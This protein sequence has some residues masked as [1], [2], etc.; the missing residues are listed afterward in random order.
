[1]NGL[2]LSHN[3]CVKGL[4]R[5]FILGRDW[6]KDNGVRLYFDLG[7]LR[8]KSK[9]IELQENCHIAALLRTDREFVIKPQTMTICYVKIN[10]GFQIPDSG[11]VET[12][13]IDSDCIRDDPGLSLQE[14]VYTIRQEKKLPVMLVNQTNRHYRFREGQWWAE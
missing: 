7:C 6:L 1:M 13:N 14:S 3:F 5:N 12:T 9:Y 11:L 4:N 2:P 8:L 10:Q